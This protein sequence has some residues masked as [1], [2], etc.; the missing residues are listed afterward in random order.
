MGSSEM[1][2]QRTMYLMKSG[3]INSGD[4]CMVAVPKERLQMGE[5]KPTI[6]IQRELKGYILH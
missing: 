1:G 5:G 2:Q 3:E 6:N 4:K